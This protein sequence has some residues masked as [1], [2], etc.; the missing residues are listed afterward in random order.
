MKPLNRPATGCPSGTHES[1]HT[2]FCEDHCSWEICRL[3]N[4]PKK[5]FSSQAKWAWDAVIS[6][7]VALGIIQSL[8]YLLDYLA[9][10]NGWF[11]ISSFSMNSFTDACSHSLIVDSNGVTK[12]YHPSIL[13]MYR[14][15]SLYNEKI[16]YKHVSN[17]RYIYWDSQLEDWK[18]IV[19]MKIKFR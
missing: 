1:L 3:R 9:I 15:H 18:V 14:R 2:C 4:P 12:H 11:D 6:A 16:S 19:E 5:C 17:E 13:G 8:Y 7:W 10:D